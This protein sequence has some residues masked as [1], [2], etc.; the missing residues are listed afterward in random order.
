MLSSLGT[1]EVLRGTRYRN[2]IERHVD[3]SDGQQESESQQSVQRGKGLKSMV[4]GGY[5]FCQPQS[6]NCPPWWKKKRKNRQE[7]QDEL[8]TDLGIGQGYGQVGGAPRI[9]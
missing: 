2:Y 5:G 7:E 4:I 8:K 6:A 9:L 1:L 3:E